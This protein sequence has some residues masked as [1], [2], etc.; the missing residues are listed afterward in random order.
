MICQPITFLKAH[1]CLKSHMWP[2]WKHSR[3]HKVKLRIKMLF[4]SIVGKQNG[5]S[6]NWQAVLK[7]NNIIL[8][9]VL[10]YFQSK[11]KLFHTALYSEN[12]KPMEYGLNDFPGLRNI[13]L[14]ERE[15]RSESSDTLNFPLH[16]FSN[17]Y[18]LLECNF[19]LLLVYMFFRRLQ[20]C[21]CP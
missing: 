17:S 13:Y 16:I 8:I 14:K 18:S 7:E 15:E 2:I 10:V 19:Y 5:N 1:F 3:V 20:R 21:S 4:S 6:C 11:S 12:W 9:A